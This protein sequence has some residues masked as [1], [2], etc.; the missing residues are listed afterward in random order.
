MYPADNKYQPPPGPN[1][2][3]APN[4]PPAGPGA[5]PPHNPGYPP[6]QHNSGYPP[7]H[8]SN[9]A[10]QGYPGPP[11]GNPGY[12]PP[13][14]Y[15]PP[16]VVCQNEKYC[17][18]TKLL[19]NFSHLQIFTKTNISSGLIVLLF[20]SG[21][22]RVPIASTRLSTAAAGLP[23]SARASTVLSTTATCYHKSATGR[24]R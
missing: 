16:P 15:G 20:F 24:W 5:Q 21:F 18:N 7:P 8:D 6:P 4:F 1:A 17:F 11:P 23:A 10:S 14:G 12:P 13:Q 22:S 9:Y 2:P 19:R 3:Y